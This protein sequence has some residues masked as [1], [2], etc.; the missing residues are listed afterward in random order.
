LAFDGRT[1][2]DSARCR[3]VYQRRGTIAVLIA[4]DRGMGAAAADRAARSL[5]GAARVTLSNYDVRGWSDVVHDRADEIVDGILGLL[6]RCSADNPALPPC[7]GRHADIS[8][9]VQG[10]GP[11]LVLLPYYLAPTQWD[12]ALPRLAQHF[13]VVTLGGPHVGGVALL[14][15]RACAPSF[16]G[17]AQTLFNVMSPRPGE[18]SLT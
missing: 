11:A 3:T 1:H 12:E 6:S 18:L 2:F 5:L 4:G 16:R 15:D 14:E 7:E 8:Y 9:K 10:S 13:T 17:M